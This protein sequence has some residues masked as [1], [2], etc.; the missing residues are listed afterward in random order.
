[1]FAYIRELIVI[2]STEYIYMAH[3]MHDHSTTRHSSGLKISVP[4]RQTTM[5]HNGMLYMGPPSGI[6]RKYMYI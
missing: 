3:D 2:I 1:M 4:N 6:T 5:A